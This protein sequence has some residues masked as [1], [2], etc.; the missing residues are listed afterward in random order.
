MTLEEE[1][2]TYRRELPRLLADGKAGRFV[3]IKAGSIVGIHASQA[4]ALEAGRHQFGL[5]AIAVKKIDPRDLDLLA[6]MDD[7]KG[8][9]CRS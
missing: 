2:E 4:E 1:I 3:L 6:R 7:Q 5:E 8:A 9:A